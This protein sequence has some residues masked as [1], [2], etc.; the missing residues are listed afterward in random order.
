MFP[1]IGARQPWAINFLC[2]RDLGVDAVKY[3]AIVSP[4][5]WVAFARK[6]R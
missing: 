6:E 3:Q 4:L 5:E 2:Q 1:P